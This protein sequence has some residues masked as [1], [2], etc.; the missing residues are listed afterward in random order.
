MSGQDLTITITNMPVQCDLKITIPVTRA[1]KVAVPTDYQNTA[2]IKKI[3][4][5]E[6]KITSETTYH[7]T[8]PEFT[9]HYV[10]TPDA[11]YGTPKTGEI[12][13]PEDVLNIPYGTKETLAD[14]LSSPDTT[15]DLLDESQKDVYGK[16][17]FTGWCEDEPCSED[18]VTKVTI[19][20]D[21]TVYGK[22]EFK[23]YE[24][25]FKKIGTVKKEPLADAEFALYGD[26]YYDNSG[27]VNKN[28]KPIE[29]GLKSDKDGLFSL[30]KPLSV[31]TYYLVETEAPESYKQP[32]E[33]LVLTV[34]AE[35]GMTLEN[36]PAGKDTENPM[37]LTFLVEN[38]YLFGD[39]V[40]EKTL[41]KWEDESD[42]TFVFSV[43]AVK[44]NETVFSDVASLTF[45]GPDTKNYTFTGVI[46]VGAQVTVTEVYSGTVYKA[47]G[48]TEAK[49]TIEK[50]TG[51]E[52]PAK[53]S[54]TNTY[55][56]NG[57]TE[58]FGILNTFTKGDEGWVWTSDLP[59][60]EE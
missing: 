9:L 23:P 1:E 8:I 3:G 6:T 46:P 42:A 22:W 20:T 19:T 26:D 7:R 55:D 12:T 33:P 34:N 39:L 32:E 37:K 17:T 25:E 58:G 18:P 27:E 47:V 43:E 35:E 57:G 56:G 40:I 45:S 51:A 13:V 21:K 5:L 54:F 15:A 31:G 48:A 44:N 53:A 4:N 41:Q 60:K 29:E 52:N 36:Q 2:T 50:P 16:W 59:Q 10:V 24:V 49:V 11:K 38:E 14:V 28:T 30:E